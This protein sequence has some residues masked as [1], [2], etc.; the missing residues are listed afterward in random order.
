MLILTDS[1]LKKELKPLKKYYSVYDIKKTVS[2]IG[3]NSINLSDLGYKNGQLLKLRMVNKIAGRMIV[4]TFMDDDKIVPIVVRLKKDKIFGENLSLNNKRG[5]QLI[6]KM[7][8]SAIRD[9]KDDNFEA[10]KL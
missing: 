4:Y 1:F 5:K 8:D 9:I 2:K 10:V 7:L 3:P 6:M